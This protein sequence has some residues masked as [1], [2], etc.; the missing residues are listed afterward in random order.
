[1]ELSDTAEDA[2]FQVRIGKADAAALD[3]NLAEDVLAE[4]DEL[5][6][7]KAAFTYE[8]EGVVAGVVK[9]ESELLEKINELIEKAVGE[10]MY[11][12]WL[13]AATVQAR[14]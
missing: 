9:G 2:V 10:K 6:L 1:M 7:A 11:L 13:D 5:D 12:Q 4:N 3:R 8:Q 14:P